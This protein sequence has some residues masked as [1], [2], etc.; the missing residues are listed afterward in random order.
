MHLLAARTRDGSLWHTLQD[1]QV[2]VDSCWMESKLAGDLARRDP[3]PPSPDAGIEWGLHSVCAVCSLCACLALE[4]LYNRKPRGP[5]A[6]DTAVGLRRG[7]SMRCYQPCF[8]KGQVR[9]LRESQAGFRPIGPVPHGEIPTS[10]RQLREA[11]SC[12]LPARMH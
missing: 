2:F 12:L 9:L 10:F 8:Q 11:S 5:S 3:C 7:F 1:F 4:R 6:H